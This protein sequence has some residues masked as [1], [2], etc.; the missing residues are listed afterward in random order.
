M[1]LS[2][3]FLNMGTG[4]TVPFTHVKYSEFSPEN[5]ATIY[6]G[7]QS[8]RL[9]RVENAETSPL[10]EEIGTDEFP[11]ASIS[12]IALGG[13]EDTV[14]VTFSNYGV[15]SVWQSVNGGMDWQVK[16]GN[17][18]DMPVRWA[19]YHP[20]N[21]RAAMLATEL[22]IWTSYSM[23]EESTHWQP[24]NEGLANVRIDM[25]QMRES[26]YMVLA[27]THGRGFY[28]TTFNYNPTT[29]IKDQNSEAFS[30]YPNPAGSFVEVLME[31]KDPSVA[32]WE[33]ISSDGKIQTNGSLSPG[34]Q[35]LR[36]DLSGIEGGT[37]FIRIKT[38]HKSMV[39]K[40]LKL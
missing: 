7:T 19:I 23:N 21:A 32:Y 40:L 13:S 1:P 24:D 34:D 2:G 15:S 26:D 37:Y 11:T 3:E 31:E 25:L 27:G 14:M 29:G 6:L 4:S 18:P 17:L 33:L 28:Y 5:T 10:V 8:G 20:E 36:L 39:Q 16:E 9:F 38:N 12:C 30:L 22:G 35:K